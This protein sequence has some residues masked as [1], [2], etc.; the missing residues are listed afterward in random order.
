MWIFFSKTYYLDIYRNVL[1]F[2]SGIINIP[3]WSIIYVYHGNQTVR[4][5]LYECEITKY[6][7]AKVQLLHFLSHNTEKSTYH[8]K[9]RFALNSSRR[10]KRMI[11]ARVNSCQ[12]N[13]SVVEHYVCIVLP[14]WC[15][16]T[17]VMCVLCLHSTHQQMRIYECWL[18]YYLLLIMVIFKK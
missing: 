1:F 12:S 5:I 14:R 11:F 15:F 13:T 16:R 17:V 3:S 2:Y 10:W 18:N 9:V 4:N 7:Q 6:D 8:F